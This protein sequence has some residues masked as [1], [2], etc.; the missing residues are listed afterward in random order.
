MSGLI[1]FVVACLLL[2]WKLRSLAKWERERR[3]YYVIFR[4]DGEL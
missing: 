2:E 4:E 1:I 3:T